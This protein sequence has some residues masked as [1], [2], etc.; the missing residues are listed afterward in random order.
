MSD[1][2][3]KFDRTF[4][5]VATAGSSLFT[6]LKAVVA[7][8]FLIIFFTFFFAFYQGSKAV[9]NLKDA[10][11]ASKA[12]PT[13][14]TSQ[15]APPATV[16]PS[17]APAVVAAPTLEQQVQATL[18]K[19]TPLAP[20]KYGDG[21]RGAELSLKISNHSQ[22]TIQGLKVQVDLFDAFGDQVSGGNFKIE[23]TISAGQTVDYQY[24]I[25]LN[26]F[27][28]SDQALVTTKNWKAKVTVLQVVSN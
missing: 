9:D 19:I 3:S 4:D 17:P 25:Q 16:Q 20:N 28:S 1:N 12:P 7:V 5:G 14:S 2:K 21:Y 11:A 6:L 22:Q 27:D 18:L 10:S 15:P 26:P 24:S 13:I 23:Q 8:I